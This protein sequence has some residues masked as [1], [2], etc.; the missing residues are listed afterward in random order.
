MSLVKPGKSMEHSIPKS[1]WRENLMQ[2]TQ[3]NEGF[4]EMLQPTHILEVDLPYS[5]PSDLS[6]ILK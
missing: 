1:I 6:V 4:N 5:D 2:D 3:F